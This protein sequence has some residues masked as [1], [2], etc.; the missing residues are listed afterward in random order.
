M[1]LLSGDDVAVPR[2][3]GKLTGRRGLAATVLVYKV[4][5]LHPTFF[6]IQTDRPSFVQIAGGLASAG[7]SLDEVEHLA[8][9]IAENSGTVGVGLEHTHVPGTA[10]SEAYLKADEVELGMG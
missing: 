2:S 4:R 1:Y 7:G 10:E 3:Q 6:G 9:I 8:R 5:A